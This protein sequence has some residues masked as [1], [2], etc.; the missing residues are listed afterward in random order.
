MISDFAIQ[1]FNGAAH[2]PQIQ[3]DLSYCSHNKSICPIDNV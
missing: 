2:M 1:I 3:R